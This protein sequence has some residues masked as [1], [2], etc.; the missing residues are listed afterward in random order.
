MQ[1]LLLYYMWNNLLA[2]AVTVALVVGASVF[3]VALKVFGEK[4]KKEK[5]TQLKQ[6]AIIIANYTI[7]PLNS[8][9]FM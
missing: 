2:L 7:E 8:Y 4:W 1:S 6:V 5:S 3:I 9:T